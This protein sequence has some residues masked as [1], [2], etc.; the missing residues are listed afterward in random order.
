VWHR[1]YNELLYRL[2]RHEEAL[3]SYE[4]APATRN[5]LLDKAYFLSHAGRVAET[6]DVYREL[7]ARDH[8]DIVASAGLATALLG[9]KRYDEAAVA[10]DLAL[11]QGTSDPD[12]YS[13]AAA[14]A[15]RRNDPEKAVALCEQ[16]LAIAPHSQPALAAL[17]VGL[18]TLNDERDE[19]LNGYDT[20]VQV[21]DLEPPAGF[22]SMDAFNAELCGYLETLHP[23]AR[24]FH[25]Q[26]LR[27][28][29]QTNGDLFGAGHDLVERV[30]VRIR[31]V[32]DRY[33]A[34]LKDDPRHPFLS[35]RSRDIR[36]SGSWSSRLGD[37]GFHVNH[38][39]P[40]GWISSCYYVGVPDV[41]QDQSQR[42]GWVKF[43]ESSFEHL[44]EKNPARRTV[45]PA[46]G[47][48]VL[49]P[50]YM[51][52]GTNSFHAPTPRTTIAFDV[53]PA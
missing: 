7:S 4:R 40:K 47:R 44:L 49:F 6:L 11:A 3:K 36:Y 18:R 39:H 15:L 48:L 26:T 34:G 25:N 51:W 19:I 16:A 8:N 37:R 28:G 27:A 52:H 13:C 1:A 5:L 31:E 29:T 9:L 46:P 17:S 2:D 24:K 38:T 12:V 21:F 30:Q 23:N 20:L 14:V 10:F 32:L 50:S 35:R 22:S 45:Q 43:G 42:Q 41:V 53:V 33:I